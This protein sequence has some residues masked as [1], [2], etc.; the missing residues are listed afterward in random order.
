MKA[1]IRK[2]F[3]L[4][5]FAALLL[6]G[7]GGAESAGYDLPAQETV[8]SIESIAQSG[9]R[10]EQSTE[11]AVQSA[12]NTAQSSQRTEQSIESIAQ[13]GQG[14][15]DTVQSVENAEQGAESIAQSGQNRDT[16]EEAYLVSEHETIRAAAKGASGGDGIQSG[17]ETEAELHFIDVGQG[18]A[19]LVK[20]GGHAMLI[21]CGENDKGTLVQ[22]YLQ[23]QGVTKLD[24]L[25]LT[26]P[27]SDHIGG[28]DVVV[29]KFEIGQV[30]MADYTKENKTY[31]D[32]IGAL[33]DKRLGW[34]TPK[35]GSVFSLGGAEFTVLGPVGRYEDPNNSSLVLRLDVGDV[36]F[37]FTGDAQEPAET[38]MLRA[39]ADVAADVYQVG[40]HGSDT[41][42]SEAF[43]KAVAPDYAV[44]S[45]AEG[46]SY[47]HPHAA[48][49]NT[50]RAMG[51]SVFRTDEQGSIVARTDG[52][53]VKWN[54]APSES[55]QA[56]ERTGSAAAQTVTGIKQS[57]TQAQA[58][59][60]TGTAQAGSYIGNKNNG[61]LHRATCK[62]LPKEENRAVFASR[63]E[64]VEA[65]YDDP[66]KLCKP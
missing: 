56:G 26:H 43:L 41:S 64:A 20:C 38:D 4:L 61:K 31:R 3:A 35:P 23:K 24:Y 32:L 27:D 18:D 9:R 62:H 14:T 58:A 47:G 19:T 48:V 15:E 65:G 11:N 5:T 2:A 49:L 52:K 57:G 6:T 45:C 59:G 34:Q 12:E 54:S 53:S 55:W 8:Q 25:V 17:A 63:E 36:S 44:I 30:F 40:H 28:A 33:S 51:V 46:N 42:S 29:T 13:S 66:C 50:L 1:R 10:A 16:G 7:C 39:G 21:D 22:R 37:L 60:D